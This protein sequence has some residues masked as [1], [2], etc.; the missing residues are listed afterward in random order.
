MTLPAQVTGDEIEQL[1]NWSGN[2]GPPRKKEND[3]GRACSKDFCNQQGC[4]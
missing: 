2:Q 4:Q 3:T 1:R